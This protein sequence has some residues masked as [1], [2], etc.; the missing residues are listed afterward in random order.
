MAKKL[1]CNYYIPNAYLYKYN[2]LKKKF[3]TYLPSDFMFSLAKY[4]KI[5]MNLLPSENSFDFAHVENR[6]A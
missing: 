3:F 2:C 4:L 5:H 1:Q 6:W